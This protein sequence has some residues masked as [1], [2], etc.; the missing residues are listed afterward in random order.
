MLKE[1]AKCA[2]AGLEHGVDQITLQV[3]KENVVVIPGARPG[4]RK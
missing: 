2:E 4:V 1:V 3:E